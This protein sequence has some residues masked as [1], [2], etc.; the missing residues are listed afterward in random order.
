MPSMRPPSSQPG[1]PTH[2]DGD[3]WKKEREIFGIILPILQIPISFLGKIATPLAIIPTVLEALLSII[4]P[5]KTN[6]RKIAEDVVRSELRKEQ[7]DRLCGYRRALDY[8]LHQRNTNQ[9]EADRRLMSFSDDL[10]AD[11]CSFTQTDHLLERAD[12][13]LDFATIHLYTL[14]ALT[15][16]YTNDSHWACNLI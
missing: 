12:Y 15:L 4:F 13:F 6:P 11:M 8:I 2:D 1:E 14:S 16:T 7:F 9:Q 3:R 10:L 5:D